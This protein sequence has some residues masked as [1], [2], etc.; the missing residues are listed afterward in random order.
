[1]G[2]NSISV[3]D[4][5][6]SQQ[7]VI[8]VGAGP[9]GL[10]QSPDG[11]ELWTAHSRDGGISIIDVATSK[12]SHTFDARTK[13][14]NRLKFTNDGKHVL[15]SD[16]GAGELVIIDAAS[17]KEVTRIALGPA[18]TGILIAPTGDEAYVAVSGADHIAVVDLKTLKVSRKIETGKS[19]D[20]MAWL[21]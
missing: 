11:R 14:S 3:I 20:G 18:P 4:R 21:K 7:S 6:S 10:D 19:P 5:K 8:A 16:L 13:R 2:S 12:V 1:M 15:V 9:E 17:R